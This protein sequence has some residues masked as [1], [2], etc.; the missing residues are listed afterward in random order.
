MFSTCSS[1]LFVDEYR[2]RYSRP[3]NLI[4]SIRYQGIMYMECKMPNQLIFLAGCGANTLAFI[5]LESLLCYVRHHELPANVIDAPSKVGQTAGWPV[6][7]ADCL[8]LPTYCVSPQSV[9]WVRN[10]CSSRFVHLLW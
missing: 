7:T 1:G 3:G 4:L 10:Q 8:L 5:G 6:Y 9:W 2:L